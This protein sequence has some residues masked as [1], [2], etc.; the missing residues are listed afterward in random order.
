[1]ST[2]RNFFVRVSDALAH[3]KRSCVKMLERT[4]P[5]WSDKV[6]LSC[7][8][9]L[10]IGHKL[11]LNNPKTYTEKCQWLKLY[12]RKPEYTSMV[13]KY[14]VKQYVADRIGD[15]YIIPTL[16]VWDS[17]DDI[18]WESLPNQFVLKC[19]HDSGSVCV[20]RDKS[21]FD[22][23]KAI[24][25]LRK[26]LALEYFYHR[27]E[28]PYK[29][30][31]RRII[32][33]KYMEGLGNMDS[34]E[35]KLTCCNGKVKFVTICTG[36][37]HDK[38]ELRRNDHFL[39][40][41]WE[42]MPWRMVYHKSGKEYERPSFTNEMIELSEKLAID[43]PHLRVDWYY[44]EGQLYFG[45]M[46]FYTWSGLEKVE[47]KEWDEIWGSWIEMPKEKIIND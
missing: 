29:H 12:Y 46:T 8:Y 21:T 35:Y 31:P 28:W 20:C 33:E 39:A 30:V 25:K 6:Y 23:E 14:A 24:E 7:L 15:K 47:P 37:A 19:T 13:D 27:R 10:I 36:I 4:A 3:P 41:N 1:M 11:D 38:P 9:R 42:Q 40:D 22:K 43:V 26:G 16:A 5:Y 17:V 34:N 2:K 32:A 44:L 18:D 45:E